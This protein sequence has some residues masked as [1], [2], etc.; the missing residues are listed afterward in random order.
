MKTLILASQ[1]PRRKELLERCGI[2]FLCMPA[3][4]DETID[5]ERPLEEEIEKLSIRKAQHILLQKPDCVVIGSDTIVAVDGKPLG[6]PHDEKTAEKMLE[7]IQGR[8][9]QVIT[10][11]A[12]LS[13]QRRYVS[14]E[15]AEVVFEKMDEEEIHRYIETG[16]CFDKAGAYGIQGYGGRYVKEIHGD[17]YAIM[18]L[19]LHLVYKE[20]K[21]LSLY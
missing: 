12:V 5:T 18:G 11:L 10:G 13:S 14:H 3:D 20:L 21:N 8:S 1:S 19:P 7:M 17:F 2:P 9:H 16:E 15:T 4:I 6:K